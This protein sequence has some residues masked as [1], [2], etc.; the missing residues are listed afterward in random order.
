MKVTPGDENHDGYVMLAHGQ[1]YS[2][3]LGN[4]SHSPC[5]VELSIDGDGVGVFRL[6][7]QQG[8]EID[9][10]SYDDGR[11]TFFELVTDEARAANLRSHSEIGL[12]KAIFKP[13]SNAP[14]LNSSPSAGGTGLTGRSDQKFGSATP[15]KYHNPRE[16]V[17]IH[18]RLGGV[19]NP[20]I[21]PLRNAGPLESSVP[22]P[23]S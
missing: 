23:L 20:A 14:V 13:G 18:L 11:F 9:R 15:L 4:H 3:F 16:F 7:S 19:V 17:T 6:E 10:P 8:A 1:Q 21:R 5:D 2:V 12:L 22:P